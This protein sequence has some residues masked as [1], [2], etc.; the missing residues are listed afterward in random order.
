M[1]QYWLAGSRSFPGAGTR[2][3][4]LNTDHMS[5]LL[6]PLYIIIITHRPKLCG[7]RGG[8]GRPQ[9]A[10]LAPPSPGGRGCGEAGLRPP[11]CARGQSPSPRDDHH[12]WTD[13]D[14]PA[15]RKILKENL[16]TSHAMCHKKPLVFKILKFTERRYVDVT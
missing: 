14:N 12:L 13:R 5:T 16:A 7:G 6:A 8:G 15:T 4:H 10:G 9:G 3:G 2:L 11:D 1:D